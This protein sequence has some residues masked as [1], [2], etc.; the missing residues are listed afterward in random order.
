MPSPVQS[1]ITLLPNL[2]KSIFTDGE[3]QLLLKQSSSDRLPLFYMIWTLKEAY[4][5]TLGKGMSIPLKSFDVSHV[6]TNG[7]SGIIQ[8]D[9]H[10]VYLKSIDFDSG[11]KVS[12]GSL[13]SNITD[14]INK[15]CVSELINVL[16]PS[17]QRLL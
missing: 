3:A 11:Y 12:V 15:I 17:G 13:D 5:K 9:N 7:A 2:M 6:I 8:Q 1:Q 16:L 10:P 14:K 4:I